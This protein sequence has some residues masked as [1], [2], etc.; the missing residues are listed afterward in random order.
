MT[1]AEMIERR[2]YRPEP[3]QE[4]RVFAYGS[5]M[6][7][8]DF[9]FIDL[10]P[11]TLYG[12]H[13]AFCIIS[14]HYRGSETH[15]G[16]V[17][18]LDRGGQCIGRMY[19]IAPE[20]AES[21]ADYLHRREMITGVYIPR[22]L[23]VRLPSGEDVTALSYVADRQHPQYAGKLAV[24]DVVHRIRDAVGVAGP[25]IDYLRNTVQHLDDLGISDCALH[26]ILRMLD[27][28]KAAT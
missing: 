10:Q 18:G 21:A 14:T 8:P 27:G 19:R 24:E 22:L 20:D 7:R 13:R 15:P 17:L 6:W 16:L 1:E 28:D 9:S 4:L 5:L 2:R 25:N 11:A 23:K 26:R 12:Y 3:G